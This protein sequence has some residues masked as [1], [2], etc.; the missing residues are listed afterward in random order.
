MAAQNEADQYRKEA[1]AAREHYEAYGA[2]LNQKVLSLSNQV[3]SVDFFVQFFFL[4]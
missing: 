4:L 1:Q 2:E 3:Q